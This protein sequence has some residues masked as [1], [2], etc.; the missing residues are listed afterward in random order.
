[1]SPL[2]RRLLEARRTRVLLAGGPAEAAPLSE[3]AAY[4]IQDEVLAALGGRRGWKVG[5]ASAQAEPMCAPLPASGVHADGAVLAAAGFGFTGVEVEIGFRFGRDLPARAGAYRREEVLAAVESVCATIELVDSRFAGWRDRSPL[6]Q[7][8]DLCNHGALVAGMASP[9]PASVDQTRQ[10]AEL[11]VDGRRVVA[12]TGGNTAGDVQR[13]LIWLA[14][15][16]AARG[17][18]L[19]AGEIV[20]TGSCTGL[21]EARAGQRLRGVLPGLGEVQLSLT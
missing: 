1:V 7:C 4:A 14:G 9:A 13:L 6:E 10:A 3:A 19:R 11:W 18:S 20:T 8:A 12:N 16:A 2:A 15:H 17:Q 21:Y 5:A